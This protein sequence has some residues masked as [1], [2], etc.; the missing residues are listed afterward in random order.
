MIHARISSPRRSVSPKKRRTSSRKTSIGSAKIIQQTNEELKDPIPNNYSNFYKYGKGQLDINNILK[1]KK[2]YPI[3]PDAFIPNSSYRTVFKRKEIKPI[4]VKAFQLRLDILKNLKNSNGQDNDEF[5]ELTDPDIASK[6]ASGKKSKGNLISR[7]KAHN[8]PTSEDTIR[9]KYWN[10]DTLPDLFKRME[11]ESWWLKAKEEKPNLFSFLIYLK[12]IIK[13]KQVI[14]YESACYYVVEIFRIYGIESL[15][16]NQILDILLSHISIDENNVLNTCTIR[17][18]AQFMI[19]RKDIIVQLLEYALN[20]QPDNIFRQE[21]INTIKFITDINDSDKINL[22]LDNISAVYD[23]P[24]DNFSLKLIIENIKNTPK[25]VESDLINE[26][27]EEE[28]NDIH[29]LLKKIS[30]ERWFP[31]EK[32][33][34]TVDYILDVIIIKLSDASKT[35]LKTLTTHLIQLKRV[36]GY[37]KEQFDRVSDIFILLLSHDEADYRLIAA[38]NLAN[39]NTETKTIVIALLNSYI[40]DSRILVRTECCDTLKILTGI[41]SDTILKDCADDILLLQDFPEENFSLQNYL[42]EKNRVPTPLESMDESLLLL[43][44]DEPISTEQNLNMNQIDKNEDNTFIVNSRSSS[45]QTS[46]RPSIINR[47][48]LPRL[49]QSNNF[50]ARSS[51]IPPLTPIQPVNTDEKRNSIPLDKRYSQQK[52]HSISSIKSTISVQISKK[53]SSILSN[54]CNPYVIENNNIDQHEDDESSQ[55]NFS[56]PSQTILS[57]DSIETIIEEHKQTVGFY[58]MI[59]NRRILIPHKITMDNIFGDE[60]HIMI[61]QH[62]SQAHP[63]NLHSFRSRFDLTNTMSLLDFNHNQQ[64]LHEIES[65]Q[66]LSSLVIRSIQIHRHYD[67]FVPGLFSANFTNLLNISQM[68]LNTSANMNMSTKL[69]PIIHQRPTSRQY[70]HIQSNTEARA[71]REGINIYK[72]QHMEGILSNLRKTHKEQTKTTLTSSSSHLSNSK[73]ND[74]TH[75]WLLINLLKSHGIF[76]SESYLQKI[77]QFYPKFL[78]LLHTKIPQHRIYTIWN[79]PIMKQ[80]ASILGHKQNEISVKSYTESLVPLTNDEYSL[81]SFDYLSSIHHDD[82]KKKFVP[83]IRGSKMNL[84]RQVLKSCFEDTEMNS[85]ISS[86]NSIRGE[87]R[88]KLYKGRVDIHS[89]LDQKESVRNRSQQMIKTSGFLPIIVRAPMCH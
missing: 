50:T 42:K 85:I 21:I 27:Q 65:I 51:L 19:E 56:S 5:V 55:S 45:P 80:I 49:S 25:T 8:D 64:Y 13:L 10:K 18:I 1:N 33:L 15:F 54:T 77:I 76:Y 36:I 59:P 29:P 53:R 79:D 89:L 23:Y 2:S 71:I 84:S 14:S 43:P 11:N 70:A 66:L 63:I 67:K 31:Q 44:V 47:F 81:N 61:N 22:V 83:S 86:N 60:S 3:A 37:S 32:V 39:L 87:N 12:E 30:K 6:P 78:P 9:N 4:E 82:S 40:N 20:F 73:Q 16:V 62:F 7:K 46:K 24:E 41:V 38:T 57:D 74:I 34:I 17:T 28:N 58:R 68:Q 72:A 75:A 69:P 52:S 26:E 48:S 35:L 88:S